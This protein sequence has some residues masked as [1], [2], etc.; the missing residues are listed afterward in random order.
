MCH[1]SKIIF[2]HIKYQPFL[3][4]AALVHTLPLYTD[5]NGYDF[6]V[7]LATCNVM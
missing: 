2:F 4:F 3:F 1:I 6:Y 7:Y 5:L